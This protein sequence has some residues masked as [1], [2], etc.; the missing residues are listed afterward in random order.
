MRTKTCV[1]PDGHFRCGIHQ[2]AYSVTNLRENDFPEELGQTEKEP[3]TNSINFPQGT[4]IENKAD[5]I[6]EITNPFF[7]RGTTFINSAWADRTAQDPGQIKLAL[8]EKTSLRKNTAS[9][10]TQ[11]K[12]EKLLSSLPSSLLLALATTSTD[13]EELTFLARLSAD[14]IYQNNEP[15]GLKY[16]DG[17]KPEINNH[18]LYEALAN[19]P[20]LPD[21]YKN[22]MVLRPGV[23]GGSEIVGEWQQTKSHIFEYLRR[24]SYIPWG[25]YAANMAHDSVR[26][27]IKDLSRDDM[28]GLR[29]LYYQR[30]Y[31]RLAEELEP[32]QVTA[33]QSMSPAQLEELRRKIIHKIKQGWQPSF[34]S[35][36][37]GWNFGF[38]FAPS[39]YRLHASHQ[40]IHQQFA[41]LPAKMPGLDD[42]SEM[43]NTYGCGDL[44][45]DCAEIYQQQT[46]S[47]LF[48]DYLQCIRS[49]QRFDGRNDRES[50][51][52]IHE[53]DK[54]ILMVPKAQTSQWEIQLFCKGKVGNIVEADP[55]TRKAI[56]HGLYLGQ[57]I[58]A[59][60]GAKMVTSIEYSKRL[61]NINS[62]QP[63]IYALLPRLPW[64][65]GAFSEAQ[66]RWI[67]GHYPEDF[68]S[69]CRQ[70]KTD[71][72]QAKPCRKTSE[73]KPA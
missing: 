39:G 42:S 43:I 62:D 59:G 4:V 17:N 27:R 61:D 21:T 60:L 22:T 19:N 36:L 31:L 5:H 29:H 28:A 57:Q 38:D 20:H 1:H 72:A 16:G 25:H 14:F 52:I 69:R 44:I 10:L 30:T 70:L 23:Q 34:N 37:W 71:Q 47:N 73:L 7:F 49:N 9:Q 68:A 54:T 48:S 66:L 64:S 18:D 46:S 55:D 45:G 67:I 63:L 15:Q 24:N 13:P 65:P 41:M 11:K 3:V 50:S 32:E 8:P 53:D 33:K 56:D 51:L 26:Y 58:L 2:P 40:Q 6:Y 12:Y 35:T